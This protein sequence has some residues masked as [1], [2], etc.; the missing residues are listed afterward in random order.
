MTTHTHIATIP[1]VT[2]IAPSY[3]A[4]K[5]DDNDDAPLFRAGDY[6]VADATDTM[7]TAGGMF[8]VEWSNGRR[9]L[10]KTKPR[11]CEFIEVDGGSRIVMRKDGPDTVWYFHCIVNS[12]GRLCDGPY[13]VAY[14][15]TK[16]VGRVV[17]L[18]AGVAA[19]EWAVRQI[20]DYEIA[21]DRKAKKVAEGF[22]ADLWIDLRDRAG[23]VSVL[24]VNNG[25]TGILAR[26]VDHESAEADRIYKEQRAVFEAEHEG[27]AYSRAKLEA[28]LRKA[29][30]VMT[31]KD[32]YWHADPAMPAHVRAAH[33]GRRG[34]EAA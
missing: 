16:I 8:L 28:A 18:A 17:G 13:D 15:R 6:V 34:M 12:M 1:P 32:G 22:D 27:H 3:V 21:I 10:M 24:T 7:P 4:H 9:S 33:F 14:M 11:A 31:A 20:G 26:F 19:T 2:E 25:K 23:Q 30:R 29:G 5:V